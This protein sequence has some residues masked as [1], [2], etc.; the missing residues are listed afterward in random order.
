[1]H[2]LLIFG[3]GFDLSC[4]LK[5]RFSDFF[6]DRIN[7]VDNLPEHYDELTAWDLILR[8]LKNAGDA[9]WCDI[10][11]EV[12]RWVYGTYENERVFNKRVI[13][14]CCWQWS[15]NIA[16]YGK[17]EFE[18]D[19]SV[20]HEPELYNF[21]RFRGCDN[22]TDENQFA[23]FLL[24]E[25]HRLEDYFAAYLSDQLEQVGN[26]YI[27]KAERLYFAIQ[28][29]G[30]DGDSGNAALEYG[31]AA[32]L[33][34]NYTSPFSVTLSDVNVSI[35]N[36]HG[37]LNNR[38]TVIGIDGHLAMEDKFARPFTKAYRIMED[39]TRRDL[40]AAKL[41][42]QYDPYE[43]NTRTGFIKVFGHSLADA[44]YSYFQAIFDTVDLYASGTKLVFYYAVYGGKDENAIRE[45]LCLNV[46]NLLTSYGQTLDNKDHGRNLMTRLILENR[47]SIR[48]L[49][50]W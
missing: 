44:D 14:D 2:Q 8:K 22:P 15:Q 1:M 7:M 33:D 20:C 10:E 16:M 11:H 34:F 28:N 3:N 48:K 9:N 23:I 21:V 49:P 12:A 25:L 13:A 30:F 27:E 29:D 50:E 41:A 32:V 43:E 31:S 6:G 37:S 18:T 45:E 42:Y 36:I 5:S 40:Y 24:R 4:G 38:N 46:A 19:S 39:A 47:L 17:G 35:R 26:D